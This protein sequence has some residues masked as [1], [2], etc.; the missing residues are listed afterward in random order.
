MWA[1]LLA[2]NLSAW[3]QELTGLDHSD[4]RG[5]CPSIG[6]DGDPV[7]WNVFVDRDYRDNTWTAVSDA[8]SV[9]VVG[10]S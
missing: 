6:T 7:T 5:P 10:R 8:T 1:A 3:L 9:D 2:V 4:G